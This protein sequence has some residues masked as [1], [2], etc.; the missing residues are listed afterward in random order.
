MG[1][2]NF[3]ISNLKDKLGIHLIEQESLFSK[4]TIPSIQPSIYLERDLQ[5]FAPMAVLINTE[6]AR[7]EWIIAPILG[8]VKAAID[9]EIGL[10]S[11]TT[12]TVDAAQEL[13]GQCDYL[14]SLNPEQLEITA[15]A[16]AI[17]EAKKDNAVSGI[18]QCL[19]M[20]CAAW[21]FNERKHQPLPW[22]Y[23]VVTTGTDWRFLKL[24][25]REAFVDRD[26]YY[27]KEIA[28]ILGIF[29]LILTEARSSQVATQLS[30]S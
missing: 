20:M 26:Q 3:S 10:F 25:D 8:E 7:S 5:T 22:V 30:P 27:L 15:P 1:C 16:I 4:V 23:G 29:Q 14:L 13:D 28:T 9:P 17:V 24:R 19:A 18:G 21:L 12:F 6:K 11:R 2:S